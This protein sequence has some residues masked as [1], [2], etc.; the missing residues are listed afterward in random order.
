M[1]SKLFIALSF[2]VLLSCEKNSE[3]ACENEDPFDAKWLNNWKQNLQNCYCEFNI[4]QANYNEETVFYINM[5][6][7]ACDDAIEFNLYSCNGYLIKTLD[8]DEASLLKEK[9]TLYT[10]EATKKTQN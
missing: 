9:D 2:V 7:R 10:C 5:T 6:N 8:L 1:Y 3:N 4:I